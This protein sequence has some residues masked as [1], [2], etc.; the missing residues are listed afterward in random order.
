MRT[1][2][3]KISEIILIKIFFCKNFRFVFLQVIVYVQ[4][5]SWNIFK[6]SKNQNKYMIE[7][8]YNTYSLTDLYIY[9]YIT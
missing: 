2:V 5:Y 7:I 1:S 3:T 4:D 8:I 9:V 6:G